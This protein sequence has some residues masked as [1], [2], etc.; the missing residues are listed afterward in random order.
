MWA[1]RLL[2]SYA[3]LTLIHWPWNCSAAALGATWR[4]LEDALL[5]T[6]ATRAIGVSNFRAA[7]L[8]ALEV[9]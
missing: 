8:D 2:T 9:I 5:V 3:D 1:L 4:A 7:D 6:N